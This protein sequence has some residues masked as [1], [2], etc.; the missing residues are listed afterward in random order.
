MNNK[1][2]SNGSNFINLIGAIIMALGV[3]SVIGGFLPNAF[4]AGGP[5]FIGIGLACLALGGINCGI[6]QIIKNTADTAD[7]LE[8][9]S[10]GQPQF[11]NNNAANN[12]VQTPQT[13]KQKNARSAEQ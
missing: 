11:T 4:I 7:Y 12:S 8:K 9:L 1:N 10:I 6:A 5:V 2:R 13:P 3:L